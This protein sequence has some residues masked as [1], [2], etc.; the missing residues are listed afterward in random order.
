MARPATWR[1]GLWGQCNGGAL[2]ADCWAATVVW[3]RIGPLTD[4]SILEKSVFHCIVMGNSLPLWI[5]L[6]D[7][8]FVNSLR[9]LARSSGFDG[10]SDFPT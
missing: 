1:D 3:R 9:S 4:V 6:C 2:T 5:S 8:S 7:W 10:A